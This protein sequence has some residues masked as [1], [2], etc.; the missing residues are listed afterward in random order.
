MLKLFLLICTRILFQVSYFWKQVNQNKILNHVC[1]L[2]TIIP[3]IDNFVFHLFNI[4]VY[5]M[6]NILFSNYMLDN[7]FYSAVIETMAWIH[8]TDF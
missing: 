2:A 3:Y 1:E 8:F 7:E 6:K 5:D 4:Y